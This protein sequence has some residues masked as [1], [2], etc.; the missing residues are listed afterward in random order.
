[1]LFIYILRIKKYFHLNQNVKDILIFQ[2]IHKVLIKIVIHVNIHVIISLFLQN[3]L[4]VILN[5][6]IFIFRLILK[7][8]KYSIFIL[9]NYML[10]LKLLYYP[11]VFHY[12]SFLFQLKYY[13]L[14]YELYYSILNKVLLILIIQW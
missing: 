13:I 11:Q 3:L 10:D 5:F 7:L 12:I 1:M 4:Q 8:M 6:L 2:L 9:I 14:L